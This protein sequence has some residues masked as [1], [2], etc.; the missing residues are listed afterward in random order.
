MSRELLGAC[1]VLQEVVIHE[2]PVGKRSEVAA[3][4]EGSELV[5]LAKAGI[6]ARPK[7]D[8]RKGGNDKI[9]LSRIHR[10]ISSNLLDVPSCVANKQH[11]ISSSLTHLIA[12]AIALLLTACGG[13]P[14]SPTAIPA[15]VARPEQPTPVFADATLVPAAATLTPDAS[16]GA[17]AGDAADSATAAPRLDLI[18]GLLATPRPPTALG[19]ATGGATLLDAPGGAALQ[20]L[21][22][23]T[24]VTVTGRS[25]NG[26]YLAA[27]TGTAVA[28]WVAAGNLRLFGADDL[29]V[30]ER[31]EGPGPIATLIAEAMEPVEVGELELDIDLDATVEALLAPTP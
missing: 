21:P 20:S 7:M 15:D 19:I 6:H 30:V 22:A 8:S 9:T 16:G 13:P 23:G 28:G 26:N 17:V 10:T 25:A 5:I 31:A 4:T 24:T 29:T 18:T 27:Y 12:L 2:S 3:V 14:A 11:A 1:C